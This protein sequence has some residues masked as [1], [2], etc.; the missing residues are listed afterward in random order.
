MCNN[1]GFTLAELLAVIAIIT[2]LALISTPLIVNY[3]NKA[4]NFTNDAIIKQAEDSAISYANENSR[5]LADNPKSTFIL[6]SCAINYELDDTNYNNIQST[7]KKEVS[8]KTLIDEGYLKDDANKLK[9]SG[10]VLIYKYNGN[11]KTTS[12]CASSENDSCYNF[13]VK[14]FV[15]KSLLN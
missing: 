4:R 1:K 5:L 6:N 8:I 15:S 7:C 11:K 10:I 13:E 2:I 9:R 12:E 14:V 3:I